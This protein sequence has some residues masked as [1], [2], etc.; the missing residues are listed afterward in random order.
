MLATC[1]ATWLLRTRRHARCYPRVVYKDAAAF[2]RACASIVSGGAHRLRVLIDFDRT[3][4]TY[5]GPNGSRGDSCHGIF[6]SGLHPSLLARAQALNS[7]YYPIEV[8]PSLSRDEKVPHMEAWYSGV[9]GLLVEG[10]R[11]RQDVVACVSRANIALRQG[12]RQLLDL[13]AAAGVPVVI[14]SAG[15]GDVLQE[16]LR[17][18]YGALRSNVHIVSNWCVWSSH[19]V[20]TGWSAPLIHMFNKD[21]AHLRRS[22]LYAQLATR[23]NTILVGDS[24]GDAA[25]SDGMDSSVLLKFGLLND[26]VDALLPQYVDT[27]DAVLVDDAP[28]DDVVNLLRAVVAA[29]P[30]DSIRPSPPAVEVGR[31]SYSD[32]MVAGAGATPVV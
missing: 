21:S 29:T 20:L 31:S 1:A 19:G 16:V 4:S 27:F 8:S 28:L 6:E 11:T 17:Q 13:T 26:G 3:M 14:F 2:S 5:I 23:R 15:V 12:V 18:Q 22:D 7:R 25:M 30:H 32:S 24:L 9:N 10:G